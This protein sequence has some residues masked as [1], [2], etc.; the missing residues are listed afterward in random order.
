MLKRDPLQHHGAFFLWPELL[1]N[2]NEN[3]LPLSTYKD[4]WSI[5]GFETNFIID[6]F[7]DDNRSRL[8]FTRTILSLLNPEN[9][10]FRYGMNPYSIKRLLSNFM[11]I[12]AYFFQSQGIVIN[13]KQSISEIFDIAP[14]S[15]RD[16]IILA[17]DI[18]NEW[19][20]SPFWLG[21]MRSRFIRG[22][23]NI[24]GGRADMVLTMIYRKK[25]I[26]QRFKK[27]FLPLLKPACS[28]YLELNQL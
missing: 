10:F 1:G 24:P 8:N 21:K 19:P 2:Y 15:I 22:R 14:Q 28:S 6:E 27:D 4:C 7:F 18:R 16:A 26:E 11:L 5:N 23:G 17:T 25:R 3:I 13:K 20:S 12:P 9:N